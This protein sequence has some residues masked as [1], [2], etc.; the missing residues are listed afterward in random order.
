MR[1]T[2][3]RA[4]AVVDMS[5]VAVDRPAVAVHTSVAGMFAAAAAVGM[6]VA[7]E[8]PVLFLA[9]ASRVMLRLPLSFDASIEQG[10]EYQLAHAQFT[11]E[12]CERTEE[13]ECHDE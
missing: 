5:A 7:A 3:D 12:E 13:D 11:L 6:S 1:I 10:L 4:P 2:K 8:L 9:R